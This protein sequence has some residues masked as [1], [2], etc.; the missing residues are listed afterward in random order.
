MWMVFK[1]TTT[2]IE[3]TGPYYLIPVDF[4]WDDSAT[5]WRIS[6]EATIAGLPMKTGEYT[7]I[8]GSSLLIP[9]KPYSFILTMA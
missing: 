3:H 4:D 7:Y 5:K 9:K 2:L 1:A 8:A 6:N